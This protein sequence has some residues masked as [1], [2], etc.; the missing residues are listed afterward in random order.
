MKV[1]ASASSDYRRTAHAAFGDVVVDLGEPPRGGAIAPSS[2]LM[3]TQLYP[4]ASVRMKR[5]REQGG[6]Q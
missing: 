4:A 1:C 6:R 5:L 3:R 2:E